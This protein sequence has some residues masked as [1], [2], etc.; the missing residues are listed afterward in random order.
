[1]I[2][3]L[4]ALTPFGLFLAWAGGIIAYPAIKKKISIAYH[5]ATGGEKTPDFDSMQ[6]VL[7]SL[8]EYPDDCMEGI[9]NEPENQMKCIVI[10][11]KQFTLYGAK[12]DTKAANQ[13]NR[14]LGPRELQPTK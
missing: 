11:K 4:F 10:V 14:P 12:D 8:R 2:D 6:M 1:M 7:Q 5:T 13:P 3:I 9:A